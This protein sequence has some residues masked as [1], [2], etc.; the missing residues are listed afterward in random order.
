MKNKSFYKYILFITT[1]LMGSEY[2]EMTEFT[3]ND[4]KSSSSDSHNYSVACICNPNLIP[5]CQTN[6]KETITSNLEI[7]PKKLKKFECEKCKK[8]FS[9]KYLLQR[10]CAQTIKHNPENKGRPNKLRAKKGK[11][12][13]KRILPRKKIPKKTDKLD[14]KCY[15]ILDTDSDSEGL[16]Y[17]TS[18]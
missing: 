10:H 4:D 15:E 2:L 5:T 13:G 11:F 14:L 8:L 16:P 1:S 9:N 12:K 3:P 18:L 17:N 7:N 6:Y